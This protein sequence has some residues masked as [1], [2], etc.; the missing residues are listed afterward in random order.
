M[1]NYAYIINYST[2]TIH[3]LKLNEVDEELDGEELCEK[4][5]FNIDETY[6][7]FTTEEVIIQKIEP[8]Q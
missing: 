4:Y 7:L 3:E 6:V 8:K 5:G 2:G 1:Q